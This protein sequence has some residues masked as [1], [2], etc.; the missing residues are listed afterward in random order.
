MCDDYLRHRNWEELDLGKVTQEEYD[1]A[2][3]PIGR[4]FL[5]FTKAEL[6]EEATQRRIQL[7]PI[8]TNEDVI[9]DPQ[10]DSIGFWKT[11]DH[12]ELGINLI[13]PGAFANFSRTPC[14]PQ[15][16][17]PFI[18]EHNKEIYT[19]RLGLADKEISRLKKDRVI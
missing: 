2:E 5:K 14:G 15:H 11:I 12:S 1:V 9:K 3:A 4:F 10:L 18:G 13:Y 16:R 17:A 7:F 6:Y 19:E 8:N